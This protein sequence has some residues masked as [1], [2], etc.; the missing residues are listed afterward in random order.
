MNSLKCK[1]DMWSVQL[2]HE[3]QGR[4]Q[5]HSRFGN[6]MAFALLCLGVQ[7]FFQHCVSL[8]PSEYPAYVHDIKLINHSQAENSG[9]SMLHE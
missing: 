3:T 4:E 1:Y 6:C 5:P 2:K 7:T 8:L 9:N